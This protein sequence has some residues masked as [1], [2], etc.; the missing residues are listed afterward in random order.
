MKQGMNYAPSSKQMKKYR[1]PGMMKKEVHFKMPQRNIQDKEMMLRSKKFSG[2]FLLTPPPYPPLPRISSSK[3]W[4]LTPRVRRG[5]GCLGSRKQRKT[6]T[7]LNGE[8]AWPLRKVKDPAGSN[9]Q[10]TSL[11]DRL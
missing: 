1:R 8:M 2:T 10:L 6:L 7:V 11:Y 3:P 4:T 9:G 5:P